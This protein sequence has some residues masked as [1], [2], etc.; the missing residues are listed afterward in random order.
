MS[1]FVKEMHDGKLVQWLRCNL[2]WYWR[3]NKSHTTPCRIHTRI[4]T[5]FWV[6]LIEASQTLWKQCLNVFQAIA[7][8]LN[9]PSIVKK[10]S[11]FLNYRI[12]SNHPVVFLR[13]GV[14]KISSKFTDYPC[15]S[16]ISLLKSHFGIGVLL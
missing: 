3:R 5:F 1:S 4:H 15:R 13:K 11:K 16:V 8:F 14:L 10:I 12:R 2:L 7:P 6:T 9:P